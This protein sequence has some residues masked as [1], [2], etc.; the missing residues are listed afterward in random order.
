MAQY[1]SRSA[2]SDDVEAY[3]ASF[4]DS[5]E[6][7]LIANHAR[8]DRELEAEF[9]YMIANEGADPE[10]GPYHDPWAI[11]RMDAMRI[12]KEQG[13]FYEFVCVLNPEHG[14]SVEGENICA[15]CLESF[16]KYAA[17]H[18]DQ[19]PEHRYDANDADEHDYY[20]HSRGW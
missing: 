4:E 14:E 5:A 18:D 7:K 20:I 12:A 6:E 8:I 10:N 13:E 11:L 16:E 1:L 17:E 15:A 19:G 2:A 3:H 9:A